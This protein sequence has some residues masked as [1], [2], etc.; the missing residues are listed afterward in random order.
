MDR[1]IAVLGS[2]AS[3]FSAI[4]S[5]VHARRSKESADAATKVRDEL[6]DKRESMEVSSIYSD[7]LRILRIVSN[8]GSSSNE[9]SIKSVNTQN[10][11]KEVEEYSRSLMQ[12]S[13]HFDTELGNHAKRLC[14]DVKNDIAVLAEEIDPTL[15]KSAGSRIYYKIEDFLP[16]VKTLYDEKLS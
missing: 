14:K 16:L 4:L 11:A 15:L 9:A 5:A 10:I 1:W 6:V 7:T 12:Q 13:Q 3:I 2:I 8:V